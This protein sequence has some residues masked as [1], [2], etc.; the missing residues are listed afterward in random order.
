MA[1]VYLY[2]EDEKVMNKED[3]RETSMKLPTVKYPSGL[4]VSLASFLL[5][6]ASL[7]V[8]QAQR[9]SINRESMV[10]RTSNSRHFIIKRRET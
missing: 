1:T 4:E 7:D 9:C 6:M 10:L 8:G 2:Q 5:K 3:V